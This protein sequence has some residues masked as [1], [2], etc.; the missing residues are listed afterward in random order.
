MIKKVLAFCI[1][2]KAN[3]RE[4]LVLSKING[5]GIVVGTGKFYWRDFKKLLVLKRDIRR[6]IFLFFMVN[7]INLL[8]ISSIDNIIILS[9]LD[10]KEV[11]RNGKRTA[12][13]S[14]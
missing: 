3:K 7:F 5:K 6:L 2:E 13:D 8:Q 4:I 1:R 9:I 12:S 10:I 14:D 11:I